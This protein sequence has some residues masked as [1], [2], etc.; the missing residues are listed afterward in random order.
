[1]GSPRDLTLREGVP[2][3]PIPLSYLPLEKV[4]V[5]HASPYTQGPVVRRGH[6]CCQGA[7]GG[8]VAGS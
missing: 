4:C 1:M 3:N 8:P 6:C 7:W 5:D 2:P